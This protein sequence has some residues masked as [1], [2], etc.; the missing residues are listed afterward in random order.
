MTIGLQVVKARVQAPKGIATPQPRTGTLPPMG[1]NIGSNRWGVR[2][3]TGELK[4]GLGGDFRML[5]TA[6]RNDGTC[7]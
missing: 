3:R 1:V 4:A 6:G 7:G 5:L 2:A